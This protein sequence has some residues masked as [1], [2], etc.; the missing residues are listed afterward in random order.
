MITGRELIIY[1]L[2][3]GLEDEP[4]IKDGVLM[5]FMTSVKAAEKFNVG[6]A[7][8][9]AWNEQ[10]LIECLKLNDTMMIPINVKEPKDL[11]S[12]KA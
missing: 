4:I 2:E 8:I 12:R 9:R 6:V 10:G 1:I 11:D 3:N 5:G 7:T